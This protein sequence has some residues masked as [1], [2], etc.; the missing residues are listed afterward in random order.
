MYK[1]PFNASKLMKVLIVRGKLSGISFILIFG[2]I[3][4]PLHI[5]QS[6]DGAHIIG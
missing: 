1:N 5:D 4:N 3:I 2:C 6:L